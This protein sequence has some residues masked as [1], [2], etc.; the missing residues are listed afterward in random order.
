MRA[1]Q[2]PA[3]RKEELV[4][5]FKAKWSDFLKA[6]D[7]LTPLIDKA[8]GEYR[9]LQGD[10]SVK[11]A[12]AAFRRATK[13]P[14]IL[15]PSRLFQRALDTIKEAKHAYSPETAA[16]KKKCRRA[17]QMVPEGRVKGN[18]LR[19]RLKRK[20]GRRPVMR[21]SPTFH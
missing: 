6:T 20:C 8:L 2:I 21:A 1:Q 3:D 11:D 14:A 18:R 7:E 15:G 13:A 12:L 9:K 5:D 4:K 10:P 19:A 17:A 16:P